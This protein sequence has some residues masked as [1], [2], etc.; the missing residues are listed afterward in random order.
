M[1]LTSPS[2]PTL[3]LLHCGPL[4]WDIVLSS[5]CGNSKQYIGVIGL[6]CWSLGQRDRDVV[7]EIQHEPEDSLLSPSNGMAPYTSACM[8]SLRLAHTM[9]LVFKFAPLTLNPS[10]IPSHTHLPLLVVCPWGMA[11]KRGY[12]NHRNNIRFTD[13]GVIKDQAFMWQKNF[14]QP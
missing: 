11:W 7:M 13:R 12:L 5:V 2:A 4:R 9:S 1:L 3:R 14:T 6:E 10:L 8:Y